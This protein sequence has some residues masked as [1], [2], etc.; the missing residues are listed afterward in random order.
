MTR[1]ITVRGIIYKNGKLFAQKHIEG[2]GESDFWSTPGGGLDDGES[3]RDG[4]RR[5][6]IEETGIAP[7]IGRLLYIQQYGGSDREF[8]EFFYLITNVDDYDVEIDLASTTHGHIEIAQHGFIDPK[9]EVILPDFLQEAD[10]EQ[11]IAS[12][13][14][15]EFTYL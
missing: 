5:E 2:N 12:G 8:L 4:L 14:V 11:D 9:K 7:E 1:R 3:L 13:E 15:K 10:I 6:L